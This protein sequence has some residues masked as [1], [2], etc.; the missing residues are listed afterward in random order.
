MKKVFVSLAVVAL[1]FATSACCNKA[2]KAAETEAVETVVEAADTCCAKADTC[3]AQADTC[4]EKV[5]EVVEAA[6]K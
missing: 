2:K 3:C 6:T 4:C 5:E 1:M